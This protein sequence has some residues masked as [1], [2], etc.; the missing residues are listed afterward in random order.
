MSR[1]RPLELIDLTEDDQPDPRRAAFSID[2]TESDD[3]SPAGASS[4]S[5]TICRVRPAPTR[6][7]PATTGWSSASAVSS[8]VPSG[9]AYGATYKVQSVIR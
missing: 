4:S 8:L 3:E 2:L 5:A 1:K 6:R 7:L 9:K